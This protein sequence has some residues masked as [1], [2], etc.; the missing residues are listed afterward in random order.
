M[1]DFRCTDLAKETIIKLSNNWTAKESV[2]TEHL[3]V[4]S[5]RHDDRY[6]MN[7]ETQ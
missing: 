6:R 5:E 4:T 7:P 1:H 2:E 3:E